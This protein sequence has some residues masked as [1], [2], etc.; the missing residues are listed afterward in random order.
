MSARAALY[1]ILL[2]VL[3]GA[4]FAVRVA[5]EENIQPPTP[6]DRA[7][8]EKLWSALAEA[9][10]VGAGSLKSALFKGGGTHTEVLE[11][12]ERS[13]PV[14]GAD[15]TAIVKKNYTARN[16]R[17]A[18]VK[19]VW[20]DRDAFLMSVTVMLKRPGFDPEH[21]DWFW[22]EYE[23][24]GQVTYAGVVRHCIACHQAGDAQLRFLPE[25]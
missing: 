14:D 25:E 18:T 7:Y 9:Q 2:A 21:A 1:A 20:N 19:S 17:E 15:L 4:A 8:A 13:T 10:V 3:A 24:S 11:Y 23:P 16:G 5:A 12:L 22:V 6:A